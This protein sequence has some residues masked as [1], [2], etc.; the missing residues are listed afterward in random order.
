MANVTSNR[1]TR[2]TVWAPLTGVLFV[3]LTVASFL[4]G[5]EPPDTDDSV[6]EVVE[7]YSDNDSRNMI[8]S[9]VASLG[10]VSL[11]FFAASLRR[12]LRQGEDG[13]GLLSVVAFGGGVVAATGIATDA[14]IRFALADVADDIDPV[15]VQALHAFWSDFFFPMVVGMGLLLLATSLAALRTRVIPVW[16]AWVGIAIFVVFFTPAGFV[17]FLLSALWVLIVSVLLY[18]Q[19][20]AVAI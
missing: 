18:R 5:G 1:G 12:A 6:R 15:A 8:A 17:A 10:A 4:I 2:A 13:A 7:F 20:R 9:V 19:E 16:L 14:A 11:V 3:V